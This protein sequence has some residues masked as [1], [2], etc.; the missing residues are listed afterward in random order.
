MDLSIFYRPGKKNV[1]ADA[2][3][4]SPA[5]VGGS[6]LVSQERRVGSRE[7]AWGAEAPSLQDNDIHSAYTALTR[8]SVD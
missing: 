1:L 7:G 4:R 2:L 8:N 3:S 5:G 6:S